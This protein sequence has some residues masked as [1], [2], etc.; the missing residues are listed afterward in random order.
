[1]KVSAPVAWFIVSLLWVVSI[2]NYLDR[3]IVF[4]IFPV[5][6]T[7]LRMT[8]A[9]L[10]MVSSAFLFVYG[11]ISFFAGLLAVRWGIQ[12]TI[13]ASLGI[14]SAVTLVTGATRGAGEMIATRAFMGMSEAFY[15]PAGLALVAALH[16]ERSRSLATA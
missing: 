13:V 1:M 5:L 7:D 2:L 9:Q 3:Q 4:S 12:R 14:W 16:S 11:V 8:D 10:G 15:M 6:R